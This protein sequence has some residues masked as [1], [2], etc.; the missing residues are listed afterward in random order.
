MQAHHQVADLLH[1]QE[2]GAGLDQDLLVV[3]GQG[4]IV[5][6]VIGGTQG[7]PQAIQIDAEAGQGL[8]IKEDPRHLGRRAQGVDVPGT[9]HPLDLLFQG[10]GHLAQFEGAK[11][12]VL[13][14]EGGGDDRH[15]IDALGFDQGLAHAQVGRQ[16][17]LIGI[18]LGV[19][20]DDGVGAVLAH[21]ELH[22]DHRQAGSGDG[23]D[24]LNALHLR[25]HLFRRAG[26]QLFDF[27][28]RGAREGNE[29]IGEG[30]INLRLFLPGRHQDGEETQQ[31][32]H[33]GQ[34]GGDGGVLE[35]GR[36]PPG[37]A[38][39]FSHRSAPRP[40]P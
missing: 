15:V 36:D 31:Q 4:D 9:G 2:E 34:Q 6:G 7:Q 30:D 21:L 26:D 14:P 37:D 24:M 33:Q 5:A 38:K 32:T 22:R 18:D 20:A 11:G 12:L 23:I 28:G 27:G 39:L 17:V 19:E 16:P 1:R 25:Q 29:N 10:V 8:R 13:G 3:V 40:V 35:A